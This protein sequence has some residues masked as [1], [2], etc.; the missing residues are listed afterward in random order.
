MV[1]IK[2]GLVVADDGVAVAHLT[3]IDAFVALGEMVD[4]A[5][6]AA[7]VV[8]LVGGDRSGIQ[9]IVDGAVLALLLIADNAADIAPSPDCADVR[10][11]GHIEGSRVSGIVLGRSLSIYPTIPPVQLWPLMSA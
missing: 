2:I 10:A 9:A 8:L 11:P 6:D 3:G 7:V 1:S 5:Y 4:V